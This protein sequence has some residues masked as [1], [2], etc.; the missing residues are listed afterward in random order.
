MLSVRRKTWRSR[1]LPAAAEGLSKA[2]I[3]RRS[4][5]LTLAGGIVSASIT[6]PSVAEALPART[7]MLTRGI[8]ISHWFRWPPRNEPG[9]LR[10]QLDDA[11]LAELKRLGFTY[12]RLPV[13]PEE[14]MQNDR[15]ETERLRALLVVIERLNRAGL[16]VMVEP[17]PQKVENWQFEQSE[18][19]RRR[20]VG[21]W[22]DLA[23]A[24]KRFPPTLVFPELVNEPT[25]EDPAGWDR[26]QAQLTQS[27]RAV[28]P[29]HT[30]VLTGTNWGSIDGLLKVKPV[31]DSNV[32]YSFH[33][34]E[35]QLLTLLG[36]WEAGVRADELG[37]IPF[38]TSDRGRCERAIAG[39]SHER[40]AAIA[41]YWCSQR[42]D[43]AEISDN[44]K[45]A[46]DWAKQHRVSV[47]MTEFGA[48]PQLNNSSRL[49]Y[50]EA[51]RRAGEQYG[52]GWGL[53]ALDDRLGFGVEP[54][55]FRAST[56]LPRDVLAALG[57]KPGR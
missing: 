53:W 42:H 39:I 30:I 1:L 6:S 14:V 54:G 36:V 8:N 26:F 3:S 10:G 9:A 57:L 23:P 5:F 52:F 38:P 44:L 2:N 12:V 49:A 34:Y 43:A 50:L 47:V 17:H 31:A 24:L 40:T 18:D 4:L 45:R 28:L 19:A 21:F 48:L 13:G 32:V 56:P 33:T 22:R 15:I 37:R 20:L 35:P 51:M 11:A 25:Y 27:I 29:D 41:R 55:S 7:A 16:A 46:V